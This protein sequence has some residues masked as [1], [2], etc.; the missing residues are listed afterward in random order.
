[1]VL[2]HVGH[3]A[4][5]NL[6]NALHDQLAAA[7][8]VAAGKL[9]GG[10]VALADLA[11]LVDDRRRDVDD[12]EDTPEQKEALCALFDAIAEN[13]GEILDAWTMRKKTTV[14]E[15]KAYVRSGG[16]GGT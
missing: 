9:H 6:A 8:G 15:A 7:V 5:H 11:V 3:V 1:M 16:G 13:G 2:D 12:Q 10:D 4:P 14:A